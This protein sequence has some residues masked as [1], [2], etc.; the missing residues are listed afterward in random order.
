M[1]SE[2]FTFDHAQLESDLNSIL[3]N[4]KTI[5]NNVENKKLALSLIDLTTLNSTDT[6]EHVRKFTE[7]VHFGKLQRFLIISPI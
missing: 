6:I 2:N 1:T 4:A 3:T 7:K 5:Y